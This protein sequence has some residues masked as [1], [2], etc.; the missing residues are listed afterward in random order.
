MVIAAA[1]LF[2]SGG[3]A[4]A[5]VPAPIVTVEPTAAPALAS[6]EESTLSPQLELLVES[7]AAPSSPEAAGAL[8]V[9]DSGQGSLQTDDDGRLSVTVTFTRGPDDAGLAAITALGGE[10]T[11]VSPFLPKVSV[12]IP[13]TALESLSRLDSVTGVAADLAGTTGSAGPSSASSGSSASSATP[14]AG[15]RSIPVDVDPGLK[16]EQARA[17]FGVDGTGVTV[18]IISNSFDTAPDPV[19][20]AANDVTLGVLPGPGNPCGYTKPVRVVA[21]QPVGTDEGR[22]MAQMVH[23]VAPGAELLFAPGLQ[24]PT[25]FSRAVKE[26]T[27]QGAD[28]IVDDVL[29]PSSEPVYQDGELAIAIEYATSRG[30]VFVSAAQNM[31]QYGF[32]G[33][34]DN[35]LA[36]GAWASTVFT[37]TPCPQ[38]V[39]DSFPGKTIDCH[40]FGTATDPDP[41]NAI[42][43]EN[44]TRGDFGVVLNWTEPVNGVTARLKPGILASDG[45]PVG[46]GSLS[47]KSLPI[48]SMGG[49]LPGPGIYAV[50]IVRERDVAGKDL[51]PGFTFGFMLD[52][53]DTVQQ[54]E[55]AANTDTVTVGPNIFG[56]TADADVLSVGAADWQYPQVNEAFSSIGPVKHLFGPVKLDGSASTT[57]PA[58][59]IR[60]KPDLTSLD[61]AQT[62]FFEPPA[63]PDGTYDFFGTSA[64]SPNAAGVAALALQY[65]PQSSADAVKRAMVSTTTPMINEYLNVTGPQVSGSG[66]LDAYA[67]LA[68]LPAGPAPAPVLAATGRGGTE[69]I[70][71][72]I[73]AL[74]ALAVGIT[75][76]LLR[77]RLTASE[78]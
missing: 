71:G 76:L 6:E 68:A 1:M 65:S 11:A 21:K 20:T 28:V 39:V 15:C 48:A 77:R 54:I 18:G 13:A 16:S 72:G 4:S 7:A 5:S 67:T 34:P 38:T 26:L 44:N 35:R 25:A 53:P 43:A 60:A 74:L 12:Y 52:E 40:N 61:G 70:S 62:S 56:H 19:S 42:A 51:Q 3:A 27:D 69:A 22:G 75:A 17:A 66:L 10:I 33:S 47:D 23:G 32:P 14:P 31:S 46:F 59:E 50:V 63:Q 57:L 29:F 55:Y 78:A 41:T 9:P 36:I 64:A 37:P 2:G 58:P 49:S 73:V 30:V 8:A 45:T 24:S